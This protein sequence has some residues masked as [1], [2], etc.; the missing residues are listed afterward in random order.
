MTGSSSHFTPAGG[1]T[2]MA[3]QRHQK[4]VLSWMAYLMPL[5][6]KEARYDIATSVSCRMISQLV[7]ILADRVSRRIVHIVWPSFFM[8][9]GNHHNMESQSL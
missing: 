9:H 3:A 4:L 6:A 8:I 7:T 5:V 2:L 1:S